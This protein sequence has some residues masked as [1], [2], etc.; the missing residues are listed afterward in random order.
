MEEQKY[1]G[2]K[3][4][5]KKDKK[6]IVT[7]EADN[8]VGV[9]NVKKSYSILQVEDSGSENE[10]M[11][12]NNSESESK[13]TKEDT[14]KKSNSE[15]N[16]TKEQGGKKGKKNR[17]KRDD[18]DEDIEKVLAELEMEY[19]G[20]KKEEV[21][22]PEPTTT[23]I[24][25]VDNKKGKKNQKLE[26]ES[27]EK[28]PTLEEESKADY[29]GTVK[30]AAQ[31]KKEKKER[32]KQKKLASKVQ[33]DIKKESS[34]DELSVEENIEKEKIEE[35]KLVPE[36][37]KKSKKKK[38]GKDEEEK[39]TKEPKKGNIHHLYFQLLQLYF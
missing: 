9:T 29:T 10:K 38:K 33:E 13:S 15:E 22:A 27:F 20:N 18:S 30:S 39:D 3:T 23:A 31:K 36:G 8:D 7:D 12:E 5:G 37:D 11:Q 2:K 1:E 4:K 35:D 21:L 14:K 24:I 26:K 17:R 34:V 16:R 28:S 6:P 19:S 32:D 25:Q